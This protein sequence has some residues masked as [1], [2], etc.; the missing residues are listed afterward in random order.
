MCSLD[1]I[2]YCQVSISHTEEVPGSRPE[3]V[4]LDKDVVVFQNMFDVCWIVDYD[5]WWQRWN[6]NLVGIESDLPLALDEPFE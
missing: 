5:A 2:P 1:I 4:T 3:E 6:G